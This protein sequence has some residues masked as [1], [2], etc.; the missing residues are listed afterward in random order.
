MVLESENRLI[1]KG[2]DELVYEVDIPIEVSR[3]LS[4]S[5]NL[6]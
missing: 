4:N 6:R 3:R 1:V 5:L 2:V